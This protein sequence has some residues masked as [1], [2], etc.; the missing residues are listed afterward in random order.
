MEVDL[1]L[2]LNVG[3]YVDNYNNKQIFYTSYYL[4]EWRVE[5]KYKSRFIL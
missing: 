4:L 3:R 2:I 1:R 5:W